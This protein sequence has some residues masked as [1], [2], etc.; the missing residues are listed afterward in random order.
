[1]EL[2]D[3]CG[4]QFLLAYG[5]IGIATLVGL[6]WHRRAGE[7]GPAPKL[8]LAD[9]YL[10]AYLRGGE[11]EVRRIAVVSLIDR[12]LL[13][14]SAT[15][16][17][18]F[19]KQEQWTVVT[20]RPDAPDIVK[21]PLDR[22]I[23]RKFDVPQEPTVIFDEPSLK[24][25][26]EAYE[27]QLTQLSLLPTSAMHAARLKRFVITLAILWGISG[28]KVAVALSRGHHNIL[29]LIILTVM[30]SVAALVGAFPRRTSRGDTVLPDLKTLFAQLKGRAASLRP[31][32][33]PNEVEM[34]AAVFGLD[35]LPEHAFPVTKKMFPKSSGSSCGSG[36]GSSCGGGG[37]GGGC[38]GC[39]G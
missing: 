31:M 22:L 24:P 37:C 15:Q 19:I 5:L 20:S 38:G 32:Q 33:S 25:A 18:W 23:L 9:P 13:K 34:L 7:S 11:N 6:W 26:E 16:S 29:I 3:L 35:A 39:G 21:R 2:F 8:P 30:L 10:I 17:G 36:C 1:M 12:A 28:A 4:P 14:A 27:A